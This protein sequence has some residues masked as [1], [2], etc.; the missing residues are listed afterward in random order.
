MGTELLLTLNLFALL[1]DRYIAVWWGRGRHCQGPDGQSREERRKDHTARGLCHCWQ[2]RWARH[3]WHCDRR[4]WHP[5][6]LDGETLFQA[7]MRASSWLLI[8]GLICSSGFGLWTRELQGL[9]R[10]RDQSQADR[11]EWSGRCVWVGQL[12]Q[13]DKESDGQR[14]RGDQK[15]LCYNHR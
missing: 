14:G 12:R 6:R 7:G 10:G 3:H 13:R 8:I 11:V 15:R 5:S 2:V 4:R 9:R 1:V